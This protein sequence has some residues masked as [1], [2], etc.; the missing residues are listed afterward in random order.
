MVLSVGVLQLIT[1]VA[2]LVWALPLFADPP[3]LSQGLV[4]EYHDI[5]QMLPRDD[6]T[7]AT[8]KGLRGKLEWL[9]LRQTEAA[10]Y[11]V[12]MGALLLGCGSALIGAAWWPRLARKLGR[13]Q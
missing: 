7:L 1:G 8:L 2:V 9:F 5:R 12:G 11:G 3:F 6:A 10:I 13:A 4:K